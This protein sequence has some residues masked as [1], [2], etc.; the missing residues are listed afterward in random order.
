MGVSFMVFL[1]VKLFLRAFN[2]SSPP[3]AARVV[4]EPTNTGQPLAGRNWL[5]AENINAAFDC[6]A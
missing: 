4:I 3:D 6:A 2:L 1:C 5:L